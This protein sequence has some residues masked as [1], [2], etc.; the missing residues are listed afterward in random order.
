L[1]VSKL[2]EPLDL[3]HERFLGCRK[4]RLTIPKQNFDLIE[5]KPALAQH[6]ILLHPASGISGRHDQIRYF[7]FGRPFRSPVVQHNRQHRR[8]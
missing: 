6:P 5:S 8:Q 2:S 4:L 7:G 1:W 3:E